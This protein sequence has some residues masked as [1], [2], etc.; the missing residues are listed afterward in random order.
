MRRLVAALLSAAAIGVVSAN[1]ADLPVKAPVYKAPAVA[2][3]NWTGFYVGGFVGGAFAAG[4]SSA[5][6]PVSTAA[7]FIGPYLAAAPISYG[8]GSSVIGGGTIGY[9][10]QMGSFVVGP[11]AEFGYM[12]LTGSAPFVG[13]V[14]IAETAASSTV[15]DWYGVLAVRF[16]YAWNNVLFYGKAGGAVVRQKAS[17]ID[18]TASRINP[19]LL[20]AEGSRTTW[21]GALGGGVEWAFA[22]NWTVKAEYLYLGVNHSVTACGVDTGAGS[23]GFGAT[24]CSNVSF[25]SIHTMKVG[26]NYLFH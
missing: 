24:F 11:E 16:G 15:G 13:G 8:L 3:F 12:R 7:P 25:P 17:V 9:N 19:G 23:A 6:D 18:A 20:D 10:Y 26:I 5:N 22:H 14:G 4:D 21:G 2:P 1:A